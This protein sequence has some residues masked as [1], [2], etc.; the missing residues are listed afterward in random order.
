[1]PRRHLAVGLVAAGCLG[2]LAAC[3]GPLRAVTNWRTLPLMLHT[4]PAGVLGSA[5]LQ[6]AWALALW[7]AAGTVLH[8]AASLPGV[9]GR[10][11]GV[12]ARAITP[13][14]L[15][16]TLDVCLGVGLVAVPAGPALAAPG[17]P[18]ASPRP[19]VSSAFPVVPAPVLAPLP[20]VPDLD[21]PAARAPAPAS[22]AAPAAPPSPGSL[23]APAAPPAPGSLAA[24]AA[25]PAPARP[26]A[27][28]A[29]PATK[30]V[31]VHTGDSLWSIA[32]AELPS[33]GR[34]EAAVAASWPRWWRTNYAQIGDNPNVIQPGQQLT[35]PTG[36]GR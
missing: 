9:A 8:L 33:D 2:L 11:A 29:S 26:S 10:W 15:R 7:L 17:A 16:R 23:A 6:A 20:L 28:L 32:R 3:G 21:R 27:P 31:V 4:D 36:A 24:P 25:P 12:L 35:P 22:A 18:S 34:S 5:A 1:V 30:P 14:L 19:A 13:R